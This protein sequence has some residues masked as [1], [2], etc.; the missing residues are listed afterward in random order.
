MTGDI[1]D[2]NLN[3]STIIRIASNIKIE[4][5]NCCE[6]ITMYLLK[7]DKTYLLTISP[8]QEDIFI[9]KSALKKAL[10]NQ[11]SLHPSINQ[12]IG[13]LWNQCLQCKP[14]LTYKKLEKRN[15]WVGLSYLLWGYGELATWIYNDADGNIVLHITPVYRNKW[16]DNE[17]DDDEEANDLAY[18]EWMATEY[19]PLLTTILSPDIAQAWLN[20]A[21]HI[22]WKLRD[23]QGL[24]DFDKRRAQID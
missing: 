12:D 11:F 16:E 17:E 19:K 6:D 23:I 5:L 18:K 7:N 2:F 1:I 8:L 13:I 21:E 4:L 15:S 20:Q 9:L 14:G 24:I 3:D 22:F 10:Q